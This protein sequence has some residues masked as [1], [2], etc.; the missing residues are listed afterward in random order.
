VASLGRTLHSTRRRRRISLDRAVGETRI[1]REYI[2]AMENDDFAFQAPV[3]VK[4]FLVSYA[5]LLRLDP[6]PLVRRFE[7]ETGSTWDEAELLARQNAAWRAVV[8]MPSMTRPILFAG[9]VLMALI[10]AARLADL[11]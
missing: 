8:R 6:E 5:R 4:G 7:E 10:A 2:V 9:S 1:R 3:Y 11:T